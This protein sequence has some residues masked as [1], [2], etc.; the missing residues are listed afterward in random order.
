MSSVKDAMQSSS[1]NETGKVATLVR[2][3]HFTPRFFEKSVMPLLHPR[4]RHLLQDRYFIRSAVATLTLAVGVATV[5]RLWFMRQVRDVEKDAKEEELRAAPPPA[6]DSDTEL[7]E[8][9][10]PEA[11]VVVKD[12]VS[13][14]ECMSLDEL[15]MTRSQHA[16][17]G[18]L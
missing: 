12:S 11:L 5:Q 13:H 16:L 15:I 10:E 14:W 17:D 18:D 1:E 2:A 4:L 8:K 3:L 7:W 9:E 6:D